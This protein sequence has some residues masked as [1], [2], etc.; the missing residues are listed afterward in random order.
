MPA[1]RPA[2]IQSLKSAIQSLGI[3]AYPYSKPQD[4]EGNQRDPKYVC[5]LSSFDPEAI[6]GFEPPVPRSLGA[7][8]AIPI[9]INTPYDTYEWITPSFQQLVDLN[10]QVWLDRRRFFAI[11]L[12]NK[13]QHLVIDLD[14]NVD[15]WPGLVDQ[16]VA[17]DAEM[18]RLLPVFYESQFGSAPD[19]TR[20]RADKVPAP[21][22]GSRKKTSMHFNHPGIAF[23]S[24][25][26]MQEFILRY[27]RWIVTNHPTSTLVGRAIDSKGK[28]N[29]RLATPIDVAVF[30]PNRNMRMSY[31][32]K[33]QK[34]KLPLIPLDPATTLEDALWSSL[35]CYSMSPNPSDW[36]G[37]DEHP[38]CD[39]ISPSS[40]RAKTAKRR[41]VAAGLD[42]AEQPATKTKRAPAVN[43]ASTAETPGAFD[44]DCDK[45]TIAE[46]PEKALTGVASRLPPPSMEHLKKMVWSLN[47]E[48]RLFGALNA[49][50]DTVWAIKSIYPGDD[51]YA[52][53]AEWTKIWRTRRA[54]PA[55]SPRRGRPAVVTASTSARCGAGAR[56]TWSQ[57]RTRRCGR[58][59][60]R[61]RRCRPPSR[62]WPHRRT[63]APA[64]RRCCKSQRR[65]RP[66]S[67]RRSRTTRR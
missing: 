52:L 37:Y 51:G 4:K 44:V 23:R 6:R 7:N 43:L 2:N 35:V 62:R 25:L 18:R 45:G 53:A 67:T 21:A 19:M 33:G 64:W 59:S 57:R 61:P 9:A 49:W 34:G 14:G 20:W 56:R 22:E 1:N 16:E 36:V 15:E 39:V 54:A 58:P 3:P 24:A 47:R 46:L 5:P 60:T 10:N 31:S 66:R 8:T 41:A 48:K 42:T 32:Q 26:D 29:L 63:R 13:P 38:E 17:I 27:V 12:E 28:L 11:C 65:S 55:T 50:R 30:T 40:S